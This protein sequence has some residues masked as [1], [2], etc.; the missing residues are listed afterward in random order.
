M[1]RTTKSQTNASVQF[2]SWRDDEIVNRQTLQGELGAFMEWGATY[3]EMYY[4]AKGLRGM[5]S[6][7]NDN[8]IVPEVQVTEKTSQRLGRIDCSPGASPPGWF[9]GAPVAHARALAGI[10]GQGSREREGGES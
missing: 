10:P 5:G 8:G 2:K 3:T 4:A 7:L 1:S 9:G 6:T